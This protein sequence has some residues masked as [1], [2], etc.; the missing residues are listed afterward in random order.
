MLPCRVRSSS[1]WR[2]FN[3]T[4]K[5]RRQLFWHD[6][7]SP[8]RIEEARQR[9]PHP[10]WHLGPR[11]WARSRKRLIVLPEYMTWPRPQ[12]D[13]F[14]CILFC[15]PVWHDQDHNRT[16]LHVFLCLQN[17]YPLRMKILRGL[18]KYAHNTYDGRTRTISSEDTL[19]YFWKRRQ[20][21]VSVTENDG[22]C[23][24]RAHLHCDW[25]RSDHHWKCFQSW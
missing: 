2:M 25:W 10:L 9:N 7:Q 14:A 12:W 6:D 15:L 24:V 8:I 11:G 4:L 1:E 20:T 18:I 23:W 17:Q 21:A 19:Y 16:C 22:A 13:L 3:N 5:D